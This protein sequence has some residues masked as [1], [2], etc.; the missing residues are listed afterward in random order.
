[1]GERSPRCRIRVRLVLA[2]AL[3]GADRDAVP[4]ALRRYEK[5]RHGRTVEIQRS[6]LAN[7]WMK[8][9]GNA[10]WVYGYHAWEVAID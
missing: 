9:Q 2:R 7:E 1:M 10:D 6:S 5:A 8:G 4:E 3:D